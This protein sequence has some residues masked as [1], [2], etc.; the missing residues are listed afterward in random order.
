LFRDLF[1]KHPSQPHQ[2]HSRESGSDDPGKAMLSVSRKK[3]QGSG[4]KYSD[5]DRTM[6]PGQVSVV[7]SENRKK[8][9]KKGHCYTVN[10]TR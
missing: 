7:V 1:L 4:E 8:E 2:K 10:D 3:R 9:R 5:S 6:N